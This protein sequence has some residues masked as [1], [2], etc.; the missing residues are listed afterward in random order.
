MPHK[1]AI[2][3]L[4]LAKLCISSFSWQWVTQ[5]DH[6]WKTIPS[7]PSTTKKTHTSWQPQVSIKQQKLHNT[8]FDNW[9]VRSVLTLF[10]IFMQFS[11]EVLKSFILK[12]P[13]EERG[14]GSKY[15]PLSVMHAMVANYSS[16][17]HIKWFLMWYWRINCELNPIFHF[18]EDIIFLTKLCS[19]KKSKPFSLEIVKMKWFDLT[20]NYHDDQI[21][22]QELDAIVIGSPTTVWLLR[23]DLHFA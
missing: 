21:P 18:F 4:K 15:G 14:T 8:T 2:T 19:K 12:G 22:C 11:A 13:E 5:V 16:N 20:L 17:L 9:K 10:L 3:F 7:F 6:L 1:Y 23:L